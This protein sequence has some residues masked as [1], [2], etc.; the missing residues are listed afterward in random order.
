MF[1]VE[2]LNV[3]EASDVAW[4]LMANCEN[5]NTSTPVKHW[6]AGLSL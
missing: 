2:V 1:L 4:L 3:G 6:C 5:M